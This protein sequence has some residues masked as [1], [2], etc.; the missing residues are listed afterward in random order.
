MSFTVSSKRYLVVQCHSA[1][2]VVLLQ[3]LFTN[4]TMP[5]L[6]PSGSSFRVS[7]C[8]RII[9]VL[10]TLACRPDPRRWNHPPLIGASLASC[11]MRH[12]VHNSTMIPAS[13]SFG[14]RFFHFISM[15]RNSAIESVVKTMAIAAR[16]SEVSSPTQALTTWRQTKCLNPLKLYLLQLS[17]T[18]DMGC[19]LW[20]CSPRRCTILRAILRRRN[21]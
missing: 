4:N 15:V 19:V 13:I 8:I 11:I 10:L 21:N 3:A 7:F 18:Y 9:H 16:I 17:P 12:H 6:M 2:L 14:L 1:G 20:R 5:G